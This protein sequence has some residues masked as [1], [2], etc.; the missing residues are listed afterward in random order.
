MNI[1]KKAL[2]VS[3]AF[4]GTILPSFSRKALIAAVLLT[5]TINYAECHNDYDDNATD[6]LWHAVVHNDLIAAQKAIE[7][8]ANPNGTKEENFLLL[9]TRLHNSALVNA[10]IFHGADVNV[11][12][13]KTGQTPLIVACRLGLPEIVGDLLKVPNIDCATEDSEYH[14]NALQWAQTMMVSCP[15]TK[16]EMSYVACVLL[17]RRK[18]LNG[19]QRDILHQK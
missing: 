16:E 19:K 17:M 2:F 8:G 3:L 5:T 10:L 11:R 6:N 7:A 1:F 9:A 18:I 12:C 13:R 15:G 4:T 14:K